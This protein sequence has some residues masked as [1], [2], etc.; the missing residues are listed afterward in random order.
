VATIAV[1]PPRLGWCGLTMALVVLAGCSSGG[2][3][4]PS[5][6]GSTVTAGL[7][8]KELADGA[9]HACI[10]PGTGNAVVDWTKLGNPVL[11]DP[12]AGV[13]D[14]ALIWAGGTWHM[15]FS[16]V[17]AD[18]SL[19]DGVSWD[20]ATATSPDLVH[21]TAPR[22]WP[23]QR[24]VLGVA[25]PDVVRGP[26]GNFLVTYQSD[27]GGSGSAGT[28]ARLYYRTSTNLVDWSP[29]HPLAQSLAPSSQDRM[30]DGAFVF[31]GHQL[32]LGFKFS[33]PQQPDVF[34][35]ARSLSGAPRGPWALVGRPDID[36]DNGTIENY[37]FV[38][39]AGRWRLVATSNNLD[40]PWLFTLAG[41]PSTPAGW[42]QWTGAYQVDVPAQAF[43]SGTGISSVDYE[44]ANSAF[45]CSARSMPGHYYYLLYAGSDELSQFGGWGHAKIGVAR[46][47]DLVHWQVPPG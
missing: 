46:S 26:N 3:T 23:H 47:T 45:L 12:S 44:H 18:A 20:V 9:G 25:S 28:Q 19:P 4:A 6:G 13:K 32:L 2:A 33:S 37:E 43:N 24:G 16:E 34:E 38:M 27:P 21:W 22:P 39:A 35:M 30:I 29:P 5:S 42:L 17:T 8:A 31:T 14:E 11:A 1:T 7:S 36:V 41:D 15:L 10:V 40:Q